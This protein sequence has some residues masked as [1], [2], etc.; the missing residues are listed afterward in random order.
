VI[1]TEPFEETW[2]DF[3]QAWPKVKFP[4]G[5]EP[6]VAIFEKAKASPAPR[7]AE[8]YEQPAL[9]LL[10]ALCREL[11]RTSGD[12]PFFLSCETAR[13]LLGASHRMYA[14][15]WLLL[16]QHDRIIEEVERGEPGKRHASRYRYLAD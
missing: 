11:Q 12:K 5:A 8:K 2:I 10:A 7:A 1:G 13:R 9:R 4:K 15:R 16:L 3:L 14:W 6:M